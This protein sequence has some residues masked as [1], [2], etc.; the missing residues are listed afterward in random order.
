V[1]TPESTLH[2]FISSE[3]KN[4]SFVTHLITEEVKINHKY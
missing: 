4:N 3:L 1:Q 2:L